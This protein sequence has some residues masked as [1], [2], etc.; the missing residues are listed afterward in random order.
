MDSISTPKYLPSGENP[1]IVSHGLSQSF[2][3]SSA[4]RILYQ[5]HFETQ[6]L[7]LFLRAEARRQVRFG[8]FGRFGWFRRR[9]LGASPRFELRGALLHL[10]D[11]GMLDQFRRRFGIDLLL[12]HSSFRFRNAKPFTRFFGPRCLGIFLGESPQQ[13]QR[14]IGPVQSGVKVATMNSRPTPA[15]R[16][17]H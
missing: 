13:R 12:G 14:L 10:Y 1:Q 15:L 17:Q 2:G 5:R 8:W 4:S 9:E 6:S 16:R 7:P 11:L 3:E